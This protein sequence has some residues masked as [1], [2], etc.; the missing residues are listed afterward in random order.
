ML[1]RAASCLL[2]TTI[3]GTFSHPVWAFQQAW[4]IKTATNPKIAQNL[5]NEKLYEKLNLTP[6]QIRRMKALHKQS[7]PEVKQRL[8]A[9]NQAKSELVALQSGNASLPAIKS[10]ENQIATLKRSLAD[11]KLQY[12]KNMQEILTAEQWNKLQKIRQERRAQRGNE[13]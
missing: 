6:E 13:S 7:A 1:S 8:T 11:A 2:L 3:V 12:S 5:D 10:K 9:L 4:E